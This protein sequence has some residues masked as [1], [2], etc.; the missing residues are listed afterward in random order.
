MGDR[1]WAPG[2]V[3]VLTTEERAHL[4]GAVFGHSHDFRFDP[5]QTNP[6]E[7]FL[8]NCA[9]SG[10]RLVV[11]DEAHFIE[12]ELAMEGLRGYLDGA[13]VHMPAMQLVV[14]CPDRSPGD[15][16]LFNL[17]TYCGVYDIVY[18]CD[19]ADLCLSLARIAREGN[20]RRDVIELIRPRSD[21]QP[22]ELGPCLPQIEAEGPCVLGAMAPVDERVACA[23]LVDCEPKVTVHS[24]MEGNDVHKKKINIK[25]E[26]E[27][28]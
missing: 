9:S 10:A 17:A 23:E 13:S 6:L 28:I 14:V 8:V 11:L 5:V 20:T 12:F 24:T 21:M 25:I 27:T 2:S 26:I 4:F 7:G 15:G 16:L 18:A 1:P 19:D 22:A 3:V